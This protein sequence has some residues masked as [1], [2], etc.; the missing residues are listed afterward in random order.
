MKNIIWILVLIF[1]IGCSDTTSGSDT[2]NGSNT[3]NTKKINSL[4][5]GGEW[6]VIS[7]YFMSGS[8]GNIG[9]ALSQYNTSIK[10]PRFTDTEYSEIMYITANDLFQYVTI[11]KTNAYSEGNKILSLEDNSVLLTYEIVSP[12]KYQEILQSEISK[13]PYAQGG[14]A[15]ITSMIQLA[16]KGGIYTFTFPGE[17]PRD[18]GDNKK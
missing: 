13:N 4:L 5:V 12:N 14:W 10:Y 8:S 15:S 18:Y 6:W 3:T 2:T 1:L 9:I 7:T 17:E 16:E 11:F